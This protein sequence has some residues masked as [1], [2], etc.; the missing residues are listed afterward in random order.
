MEDTWDDLPDGQNV[1]PTSILIIPDM[2]LWVVLSNTNLYL[3]TVND[4]DRKQI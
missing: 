3:I 2:N 1:R 4:D